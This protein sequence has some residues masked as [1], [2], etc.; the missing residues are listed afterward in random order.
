M[1]RLP[2]RPKRNPAQSQQLPTDP[3]QLIIQ[4][5][6]VIFDFSSKIISQIDALA[7]E[8]KV[9]KEEIKAHYRVNVNCHASAAAVGT[10]WAVGAATGGGTQGELIASP[11]V[12]Q[13]PHLIFIASIITGLIFWS[14]NHRVLC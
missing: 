2:G 7:N 10:L 8:N 5:L 6:D 12:L 11:I 3:T 13:T 1:K 4:Y 9:I 14:R